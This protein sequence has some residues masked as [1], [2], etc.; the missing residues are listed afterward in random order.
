MV[1]NIQQIVRKLLFK[2]AKMLM[3]RWDIAAMRNRNSHFILSSELREH[4]K[5]DVITSYRYPSPTQD[6]ITP[7]SS[8][9]AIIYKIPDRNIKKNGLQGQTIKTS[10]LSPT[11]IIGEAIQGKCMR[12]DTFCIHSYCV[13]GVRGYI[14]A[15]CLQH[16]FM[17]LLSMYQS[18]SLFELTDIL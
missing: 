15:Q 16:L 5:M 9:F 1:I 12:L 7:I 6:Y 10:V 8:C 2:K 17:N 13:R 11:E 3:F 18:Q 4:Q 14:S